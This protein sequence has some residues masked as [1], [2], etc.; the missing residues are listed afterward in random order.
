MSADSLKKFRE[1][2]GEEVLALLFAIPG[3]GTF[4]PFILGGVTDATGLSS[5]S[6]LLLLV[7]I[8]FLLPVFFIIGW[9]TWQWDELN[10][11]K[12]QALLVIFLLATTILY[13]ICDFVFI[14][15]YPIWLDVVVL[16]VAVIF[17]L[18]IQIKSFQDNGKIRVVIRT[19][20][21]PIVV[22]I[23]LFSW[24]I[25]DNI[26]K[27]NNS[28]QKK[29]FGG[30]EKTLPT[31]WKNY[32]GIADTT[33]RIIKNIR[34]MLNIYK[35]ESDSALQLFITGKI[36]EDLNSLGIAREDS[37]TYNLWKTRH[38]NLKSKLSIK[39][40][41]N[42]N[43]KINTDRVIVSLLNHY[44]LNSVIE[45]SDTIKSVQGTLLPIVKHL[46]WRGV[47]LFL[48]ALCI[49][50]S[51]RLYAIDDF[52]KQ[53]NFFI[54]LL[55]LLVVPLFKPIEEKDIDPTRSSW[56]L[57]FANWNFPKVLSTPLNEENSVMNNPAGRRILP[58]RDGFTFVEK[59]T[60]FV[61]TKEIIPGSL[62]KSIKEIEKTLHAKLAVS[63]SEIDSLLKKSK[64]YNVLPRK[65]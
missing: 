53:L 37:T 55:I 10:F 13:A 59:D 34:D 30:T 35:A 19:V 18:V 63:T 9:G 44:A 57:A 54:I 8:Y 46:R 23:A 60:S 11:P 12:S 3:F 65:N 61:V 7:F 51:F 64:P 1:K 6:V 25:Y 20:L 58:L 29:I 47:W 40:P 14:I 28:L 4:V 36:I 22:I 16:A 31:S 27:P 42:N 24:I 62:D 33:D 48:F 43:K 21:L 41:I 39:G 52:K 5:S 45:Y 38:N 15:H 17:F 49:V 2:F 50:A 32:K 56:M 26:D